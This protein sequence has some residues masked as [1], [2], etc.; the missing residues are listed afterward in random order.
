MNVEMTLLANGQCVALSSR[1]RPDPGRPFHALWSF[2]VFQRPDVMN[3][4][5]SV[6][7]T[8]FA[9]IGQHP[10]DKFCM[11]SVPS[12]DGIIFQFDIHTS[13]QRDSSPICHQWRVTF[14]FNLYH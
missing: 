8:S 2:Q 9:D 14:P 5:F 1:H 7:T 4:D 11:S 3:L 6:R 10:L 12:W 13:S